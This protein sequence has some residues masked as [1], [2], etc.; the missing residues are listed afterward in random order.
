[1]IFEKITCNDLEVYHYISQF[2]YRNYYMI[3]LM[4]RKNFGITEIKEKGYQFPML[5]SELY[6]GENRLKIN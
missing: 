4:S 6:F 1:M 5:I 2:D 3:K